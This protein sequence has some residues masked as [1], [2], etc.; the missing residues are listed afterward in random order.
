M[1]IGI[2]SVVLCKGKVK[3]IPQPV[4]TDLEV[5]KKLRLPDFK[6]VGT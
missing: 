6:A 4:W 5:S 2:I 3:A 1:K